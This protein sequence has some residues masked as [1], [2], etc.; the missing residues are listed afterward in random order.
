MFAIKQNKTYYNG[1][2][3][4]PI[5]GVKWYDFYVTASQ[6]AMKIDGQVVSA[7]SILETLFNVLEDELVE[8][9]LD[10]NFPV[11]LMECAALAGGIAEKDKYIQEL[12]EKLQQQDEKIVMLESEAR[13]LMLMTQNYAIAIQGHK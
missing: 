5:S 13:K 12:K 1:E 4:G 7:K 3:F 11:G 10:F 2:F 8:I 6:D 9:L